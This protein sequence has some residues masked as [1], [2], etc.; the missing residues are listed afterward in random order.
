MAGYRGVVSKVNGG[1]RDRDFVFPESTGANAHRNY[2]TAITRIISECSL[3]CQIGE[4]IGKS[5]RAAVRI[6][7]HL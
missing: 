7:R 3:L 5:R 6:C 2:E 4:R 1:F